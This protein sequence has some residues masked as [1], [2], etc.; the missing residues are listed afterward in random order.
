MSNQLALLTIYRLILLAWVTIVPVITILRF[1]CS[2]RGVKQ[3]NCSSNWSPCLVI[4]D[5]IV[6]WRTAEISKAELENGIHWV[7]LRGYLKRSAYFAVSSVFGIKC[8]S[9]KKHSNFQVERFLMSLGLYI[10]WLTKECRKSRWN[11]PVWFY[12]WTIALII[13]IVNSLGRNS[14]NLH[15]IPG[16]IPDV[17]TSIS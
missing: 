3:R 9:S 13:K 14:N 17:S 4:E 11:W 12:P 5:S 1:F 8:W 16:T 2:S 6:A 10:D 7:H 15:D